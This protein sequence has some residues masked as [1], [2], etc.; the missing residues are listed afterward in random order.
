MKKYAGLLV[1]LGNPGVEY[2]NTRHNFGFMF[3]DAVRSNAGESACTRLSVG[4]DCMAWDCAI[5]RSKPHW[6]IAKPLTYMNLSG[7]AVK[8]LCNK[9][10]ITP[11]N[12][13]VAHDDLDLPLG[14]MKL[15]KGG[16]SA[17]HNGLKSIMEELGSAQFIRLR[18][19]IGRPDQRGG[20]R[21]YVLEPFEPA[22]QDTLDATL[23]AAKKGLGIFIRR[24]MPLAVQHI[25][26][27]SALSSDQNP[28]S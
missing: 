27:F 14:K 1:G 22:E 21:D 6:I 15:K 24:G 23:A 17:G 7:I 9:F 16:G 2:E 25:N 4:D 13:V 10:G 28:K 26:S 12:V 5:I 11:E 20:V 8:R 19:G 3:A 18:M